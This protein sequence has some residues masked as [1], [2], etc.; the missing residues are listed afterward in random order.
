MATTVPI[1]IANGYYI[2]ESLPISAQ[3]CA[4]LYPN[5]VQTQ[6]LSQET[7]FGTPGI[8]QLTTTGL[9]Q[10]ENRGSHVKNGIPY[11]VNGTTL[12]RVNR[13]INADLS[14]SFTAVALGT[15]AGGGRVSM[16]DNGTQLMVLVP[17]GNGYIYNED[18]GT[19]FQQI[20]D[21][22]FTANGAP[23]YVVFLDGY[24]V[25][26]TDS[27]KFIV[28]SLNDGL[29][30]NALDFGSAEADPDDIVAPN[31]FKNQLFILGSEVIEVFQNIGGAFFPFQRVNGFIINKGL[32]APASIVNVADTFMFIG[33]GVNES[34]AVWQ[35]AGSSAQKVSNTAI[36][37]ALSEATDAEIQM[38][39]SFSYFQKGANFIGFTV[40]DNTFVYDTISTRWHQRKSNIDDIQRRYRVN[41]LVTAYGRVLVGDSVDGRIGELSAN[42]YTEYGNDIKR[43]FS[44]PNFPGSGRIA[45]A[46]LTCESGVGN[47]DRS[48]PMVGMEI[49]DN[50]GKTYKYMLN[51]A[52][53]K[54][55]EYAMRAIWYK[56]GRFSRYRMIRFT[57]SDPVK[58][59]IIKLEVGV[60]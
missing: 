45:F 53:G 23:Q 11:F 47:A 10:Q 60:A 35:L 44:T 8:S 20:T 38:A 28:S 40:G 31:V 19:P 27:K 7:L 13:T 17:G 15:V 46:E 39:F 36:D 57:I 12:Y 42:I 16:A 55:G 14:E 48:N 6:G 29:S 2:S 32:A 59:V 56:L 21:V 22:D 49:S 33:G 24:F 51:R 3:E 1:P 30:W 54:I 34:P 26:T 41:S 25:V 18:A 37:F 52:L 5:I 58:V 43:V 50:G 9:V 4:N